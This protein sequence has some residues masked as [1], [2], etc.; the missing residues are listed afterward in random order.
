MQSG[1]LD[2]A[3]KALRR[4]CDLKPKGMPGAQ[5]LL[6]EVY[7]QK[8]NYALA[9][10]AFKAYLRELPDAPNAGQVKEAIDRLTQALNKH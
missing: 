6:G 8:K 5:L 4:A 3:E 9:I 1:K 10:E 2:D 7:F